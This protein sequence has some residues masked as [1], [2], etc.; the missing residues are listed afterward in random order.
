MLKYRPSPYVTSSSTEYGGRSRG[1]TNSRERWRQQNVN[2]AFSDLRRLVPTYPPDRKLSK[3]DI[4][5]LAIKYIHFL[6]GVL[7]DQEQEQ[8]QD[9]DQGLDQV[10]DQEQDKGLEQSPDHSPDQSFQENLQENLEE[11]Q[12]SCYTLSPTLSIDSGIDWSPRSLMEE[13]DSVALSFY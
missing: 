4:L 7:R 2:G 5:R 13:L 10:M 3:N 8:S 1:V 12:G 6:G 9:Q 11:N